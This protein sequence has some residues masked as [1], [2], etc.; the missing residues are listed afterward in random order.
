MTEDQLHG[1]S[2]NYDSVY[3]HPVRSCEEERRGG[4]ELTNAAAGAS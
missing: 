2:D 3:L 4:G 1:L